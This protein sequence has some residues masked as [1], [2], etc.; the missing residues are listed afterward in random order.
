VLP[1]PFQRQADGRLFCEE[2]AANGLDQWADNF[3]HVTVIAPTLENTTQPGGSTMVW[4]DPATLRHSGEITLVP[5]PMAYSLPRFLASIAR[6]RRTLIEHI[7]RNRYLQFGVGGLVGDWAAVGA[8]LA[9]SRK[10][11]YSVHADRVE[12]EVLFRLARDHSP[13]RRMK[14]QFIGH[15]TRAYHRSIIRDCALGLW[16]GKECYLAYSPWAR[17]NHL[18]HDIHL[19][20]SDAIPVAEL[21]VKCEDAASDTLR[22]VYAGRLDP[23]KAPFDWLRALRTAADR[24]VDFEA[25]WLGDGPLRAEFK[26]LVSTLGLSDRVRAPGFVGRRE[27]LRELRR[28]DIFVFTH[29]TP[30][31]PRCLLESLVSGTPIVGYKNPFAEDL[32]VGRGGGVFV[33]IGDWQ[34]LGEEIVAINTDRRQLAGH[35]RNAA[36]NGRRF[37]DE[38]VFRERSDLIHR[39][40]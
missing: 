28:A 38:T 6:V 8:R 29:I 32:T 14:A 26:A 34:M 4:R 13:L 19:K 23:M 2:Q 22:I 5:V 20:P 30:E 25:V 11:P 31:S 36:H 7:S 18:I 1:V 16:H 27:L 12:Y 3:S 9:Q 21:E 35:M 24:G 37:N 15:L 10:L 33:P 17:E 39:F 40:S